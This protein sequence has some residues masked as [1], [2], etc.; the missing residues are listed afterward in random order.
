MGND[1]AKNGAQL[2]EKPLS[3]VRSLQMGWHST[4]AIR[5]LNESRRFDLQPGQYHS[6]L[7]KAKRM[8]ILQIFK[9]IWGT[10][11]LDGLNYES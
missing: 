9:K 7:L 2:V 5:C 8:L 11:K 4:V 1:D 6:V 10:D 3:T